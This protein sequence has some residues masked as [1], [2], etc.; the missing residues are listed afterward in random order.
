MISIP[1]YDENH[2]RMMAADVLQS[3]DVSGGISWKM[4]YGLSNTNSSFPYILTDETIG[5]IVRY[6][7]NTSASY[8]INQSSIL[9]CAFCVSW[10]NNAIS[11]NRIETDAVELAFGDDPIQ[12]SHNSSNSWVLV[13]ILPWHEVS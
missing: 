1:Y 3:G 12:L 2:N 13:F 7:G 8:W 11:G 4:C 5:L 9:L 10:V 6:S